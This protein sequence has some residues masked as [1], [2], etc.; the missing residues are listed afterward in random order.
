MRHFAPVL[1]AVIALA[2]STDP[3]AAQQMTIDFGQQGSG[4]T[5]RLVQLIALITILSIAPSI[6]MMV[7]SFVR[8]VVVLSLLRTAI[9]IQQSPPNSV[10]ISL[11]LF[12]T[13]FVMAPTFERAYKDGIAPLMEEKIQMGEAFTKT[14]APLAG[15]ML[16]HVRESDLQLF[17]N[18]AKTPPPPTAV[19]PR[20]TRAPPTRAPRTRPHR[21]APG[22][23]PSA[24]RSGSRTRR[25]GSTRSRPTPRRS[26]LSS[27]RC[28]R[29][30]TCTTT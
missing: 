20:W 6:L 29:A 21:R 28:R 13:A 2:V 10:I 8:I 22:R 11:A 9:G 5:G 18:L 17:F 12:L 19:S 3:A 4:M 24:R 7:T 1:V 23:S 30:A 15:F 16:K 14:T 26:L 27:T 25:T